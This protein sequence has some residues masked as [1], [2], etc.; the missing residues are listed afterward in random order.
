MAPEASPAVRIPVA[1]QAEIVRASEKDRQVREELAQ[2]LGDLW[3]ASR[4]IAWP[5]SRLNRQR[6]L[7]QLPSSSTATAVPQRQVQTSLPAVVQRMLAEQASAEQLGRWEPLGTAPSPLHL[8][9]DLLFYWST[10]GRR[11]QTPGEEY[12]DLFECAYVPGDR[13]R[14]QPLSWRQRVVQVLT[15]AGLYSHQ[16]VLYWFRIGL[17]HL[18]GQLCH[19]A[20]FKRILSGERRA[21]LQSCLRLFDSWLGRWFVTQHAGRS[22]I[23]FWLQWLARLHLA[24][25]YLY[26]R[27]YEVAKRLAGVRLVHIGRSRAYSPRYDALG[28]LIVL[29]LLLEPIDALL[30]RPLWRQRIYALVEGAASAMQRLR[31]TLHGR[32]HLL[33]G[34]PSNE[35]NSNKRCS[36]QDRRC[37]ERVHRTTGS[38]EDS[39]ARKQLLIANQPSK[40][41]VSMDEQQATRYRCVLCLD[42]CNHPTCTACGHVFCWICI[43]D[44]VRQQHTCPVC[45]SA[46]QMTDLVCLSG[47][48]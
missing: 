19:S 34:E 22:A 44:W 37:V 9:A 31:E 16:L 29:Q 27:Y 5:L 28:L 41:P 20:L 30:Q 35:P 47:L 21:R 3:H 24:L 10:V 14:I 32:V 43:L 46:A 40:P 6:W 11:R 39:Q 26:G 33:I 17:R 48:G 18:D 7:R 25:F 13:I 2:A 36:L 8:A 42:R 12:C 23:T 4:A 38:L 1:K 15:Y 45:R